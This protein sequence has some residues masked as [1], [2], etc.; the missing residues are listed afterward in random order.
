MRIT[1]GTVAMRAESRAAEGNEQGRATFADKCW[2]PRGI[3]QNIA[4]WLAA[5]AE[6]LQ[7][8]R[9]GA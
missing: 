8:L 1:H 3:V 2:A 4:S 9:R 6:R 7:L 5:A